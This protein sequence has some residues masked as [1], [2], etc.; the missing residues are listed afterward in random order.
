M[1]CSTKNFCLTI[2]LILAIQHLAPNANAQGP[3]FEQAETLYQENCAVCHGEKLEGAAQ[4]VSLLGQLQHGVSVSAIVA[5]ISK[6]NTAAGMPSWGASLSGAEINN[7]AL[8][9]AELR[10]SID[11]DSF[12]FDSSLH[13]PTTTQES[14]LHKFRFEVIAEDLD[15]EPFS[16]AP[17]AN[18]SFLV[19]EKKQGLRIV[20]A[21][22]TS[23]GLIEGT[24]RVYE[25]TAF[26]TVMNQKIGWGWMLDVVLHPDYKDNGWI[27]LMYT[28]RC[29]NCNELSRRRNATV[30]M[31]KIV[32]GRIKK[33]RWI[34]EEIIFE[35]R[36]EHYGTVPDIVAGGRMTFDDSGHLYFS[37]GIKG[38]D[39]HS[40]IQDLSTPW[41]KIHRVNADGSIP[42]DNPFSKRNNIYK[43]I[44]SYGHRNPQG[45]EFNFTTGQLWE[46]EMGPRGGDELNHILPGQNYGWPLYSLGMNYDGTIVNYGKFLS[47]EFKLSDIVQPVADFTP[48]PAIGSFVIYEGQF[49]SEWS[50]QFIISSLKGRS[51]YR[52]KVKNGVE[53]EREILVEGLSRIRDIEI[54][55]NGELLL[56]LEHNSGSKIVRMTPE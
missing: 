42:D 19:T 51:L 13:I 31:N 11:Y 36:R 46:T 43:S 33:G 4:G 1:L 21:D 38:Y 53:I 6:G 32:R 3:G 56:L 28:D 8:M 37:V 17:L 25:E 49:F 26:V 52:V 22:G 39:N 34:D 12:H 30:S 10:E 18:G 24:P 35:A 7:L 9:I 20:E 27:Y 48:A 23:S 2:L 29:R 14:A 54:G 41:G 50:G 44:Y 55:N 47:I 40:G 15:A 5:S 16:L 45:L